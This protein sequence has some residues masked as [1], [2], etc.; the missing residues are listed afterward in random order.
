ML[1][2]HRPAD[3][4]YAREVCN[5][6]RVCQFVSAYLSHKITTLRNQIYFYVIVCVIIILAIVVTIL[7]T[8]LLHCVSKNIPDVFSY[9]SRK[10]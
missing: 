1:Q 5:G 7:L 6:F 8:V 10:H 2:A 4:Q 3:L 9:N